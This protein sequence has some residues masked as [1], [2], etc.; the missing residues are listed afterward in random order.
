MQP[1]HDDC[2]VWVQWFSNVYI[3]L[4]YKDGSR[5]TNVLLGM[6]IA[7]FTQILGDKSEQFKISAA[8]LTCK[9]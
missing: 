7:E 3:F 8:L 1:T 4:Y 6:E 9:V 2:A 5:V